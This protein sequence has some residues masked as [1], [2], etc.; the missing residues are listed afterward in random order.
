MNPVNNQ[1]HHETEKRL[2][3]ALVTFLE[4]E[5]EPTVGQLCEL[6]QINRSTFYRHYRDIPD[7]ME[8]TENEL[9][10]GLVRILI[11]Q[12]A[13]QGGMLEHMIRYIGQHQRFYRIYLKEHSDNSFGPG[14]QTIWESK[15]KPQF[16]SV[17]VQDEKKMLYYY[18][19]VRAGVVQ[20]IKLW[21]E[22]ACMETP[23]E[24]SG[25]IKAMLIT[26][27]RKAGE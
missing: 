25:I 10:M 16:Q 26:S 17:G 2:R 1:L 18:Q 14:I 15:L 9:Q 23:E 24:I 12:D 3:E 4:Q 8:K 5:Q 19:F 13:L 7:L 21:I 11:S 20:I 22:G 27:Y 6:A